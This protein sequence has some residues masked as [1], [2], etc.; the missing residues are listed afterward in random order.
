MNSYTAGLTYDIRHP[1]HP[2]TD[3]FMMAGGHCIPTCYALWIILYEA[4]ARKFEATKG[5][6]SLLTAG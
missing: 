2:L 3:K 5:I 1:K 6:V 4:L